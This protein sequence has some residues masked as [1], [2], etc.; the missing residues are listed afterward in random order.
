MWALAS[1]VA[2]KAAGGPA[3]PFRPGRTDLPAT[4]GTP[5]GRL[6]DAAQGAAH[7]RDVFGR[8][9][10]TDEDIVA[11]SGAHALG[12]CHADRSGFEGPWTATPRVFDNSYFRGVMDAAWTPATTAAGCKQFVN[13]AEGTMMLPTDLALKEDPAL[14]VFTE[15]YVR[16]L[17]AACAS[18]VE[19]SVCARFAKD[20][21]A[22]AKAFAKSYQKLL[23]LGYPEGTLGA[24]VA[25]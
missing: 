20:G 23:E 4:A 9:G 15:R 17:V 14:R 10:L 5:D 8:M 18:E 2:I 19:P 1:I 16:C 7:L 22:F 3:V 13:E 12:A 6:P 25:L 11:L 24:P 21:E